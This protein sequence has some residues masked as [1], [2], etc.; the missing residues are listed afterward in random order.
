MSVNL[1]PKAWTT[2]LIYITYYKLLLLA[3]K[4]PG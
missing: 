1:V 2:A 3:K 4:H